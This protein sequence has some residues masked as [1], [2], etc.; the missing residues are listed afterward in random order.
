MIPAFVLAFLSLPGVKKASM[1]VR[2]DAIRHN[3]T[4]EAGA[5]VERDGTYHI[6]EGDYDMDT[7]I[8]DAD[9]T[10]IVHTHPKEST[11]PSEKDIMDALETGVPDIV[12]TSSDEWI[13][14]PNGDVYEI[15]SAHRDS[16]A[17]K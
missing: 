7:I 17:N 16:E 14:V 15:P 5:A 13:V 12:I 6:Y 1:V 2:Q 11:G 4:I 10:I 3:W 8:I 9:T